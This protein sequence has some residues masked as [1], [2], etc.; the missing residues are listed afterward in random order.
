MN[1]IRIIPTKS[2]SIFTKPPTFTNPRVPQ[3]LY[4]TLN[5]N[6][7]PNPNHKFNSNIDGRYK[8]MYGLKYDRIYIRGE[9]VRSIQGERGRG[10]RLNIGRVE[11]GRRGGWSEAIFS[12]HVHHI[13]P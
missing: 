1:V 2:S 11:K 8:G 9:K 5:P 6:P 10:E 12:H 4:S 13:F 7:N 3:S